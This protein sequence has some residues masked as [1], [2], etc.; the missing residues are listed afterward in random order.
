MYT[1]SFPVGATCASFDFPIKIND[2]SISEADEIFDIYVVEMLLPY[3]VILGNKAEV[4][5]VDN[6]C[7]YVHN[8]IMQYLLLYW[9]CNFIIFFLANYK[10]MLGHDIIL[11]THVTTSYIVL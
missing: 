6:D 5:I 2:D 9:L 3:G 4:I 8:Y 1:V 10:I 11:G 7:K